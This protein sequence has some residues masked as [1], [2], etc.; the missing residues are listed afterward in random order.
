MEMNISDL[1]KIIAES[2]NS[3]WFNTQ[4]IVIDFSHVEYQREFIGISTFMEFVNNQIIGWNQLGENIPQELKGSKDY[5]IRVEQTVNHFI[6][7]NHNQPVQ[8]YQSPWNE[9]IKLIQSYQNTRIFPFES[10]YTD[11]LI[12]IF[13]ELP[14][15]YRAAFDFIS[16]NGGLNTNDK[17]SLI[18]YL[19]S[20]EFVSK[21]KSEL[22]SRRNLEKK[23]I[24]T[25]RNE[26]QK[27]FNEAENQLGEH[28]RQN[29]EKF[30]LASTSIDQ[31]RAS[32]EEAFNQWFNKTNKDDWEGWYNPTKE[33]IA[34]LE[35]TYGEKLKLEEPAKYWSQRAERLK[36][37]GWI[38]LG[39]LVFLVGITC[40]SLGEILWMT[41]EQIYSSWFGDDKSAAIR[42]AIVYVTLI[43]FIAFALRAII[44][45]MFS[46]FHLAR[47]SEERY[48]LTYFYLS[49]LK[50]SNVSDSDR[51]LIMQ[52]LFSRADTGLLKEDSSPTMPN[53]TITRIITR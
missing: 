8:H 15:H 42:W 19:L 41:P 18:G 45:F 53:D 39:I 3:D 9:V 46:S 14:K 33:K 40:W 31:L 51:Q 44:K 12:R 32:K 16:A 26:F 48:T 50:D 30:K 13:R 20:Y 10:P 5:F 22:T 34:E 47:D 28:L 43:S 4:K 37:Q 23:S 36:R 25:L 7:N 29:N 17:D 6:S 38:A 21:D 52:S 2:L 35:K 1:R 24:A 49:L 11:F 27:F